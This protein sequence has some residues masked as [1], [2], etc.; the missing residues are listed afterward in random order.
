MA[1]PNA[2]VTGG[3]YEVG[4]QQW[5]S[6]TDVS[7]APEDLS[8]VDLESLTQMKADLLSKQG[9]GAGQAIGPNIYNT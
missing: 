7:N 9:P 5:T 3:S 2:R 6:S 4:T 1:K 8:L